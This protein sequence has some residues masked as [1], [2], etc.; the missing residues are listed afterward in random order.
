MLVTYLQMAVAII[1]AAGLLASFGPY[2]FYFVMRG[3]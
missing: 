2:V 1:R 3:C